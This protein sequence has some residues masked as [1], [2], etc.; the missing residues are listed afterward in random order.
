[1]GKSNLILFLGVLMFLVGVS[2]KVSG[3]QQ[4]YF[5]TIDYDKDNY[6]VQGVELT[7]GGASDF[8]LQSDGKFRF[9]VAS[10]SNESLFSSQLYLE[11]RICG[12]TV[13][14]P[15]T[16]KVSG[17]CRMLEKGTLSLSIPYY[18]NGKSIN[19]YDPAGK[20][21]LAVDISDFAD[22]CGD[23]ICQENENAGTCQSDC[24]SG[25]SDKYCDKLEDGVC[26]PDCAEAE[27]QDCSAAKGV[28]IT[29][30]VIIGAFLS[31]LIVAAAFAV[32]MIRKKRNSQNNR[33]Q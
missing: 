16:Q 7:D 27:D 9:E 1:M 18:P 4:S 5:L 23:G 31:I 33:E 3:G 26:D 14:D 13:L 20:L 21:I 24:R 32:Y 8:K 29:Q 15:V 22:L 11:K 17:G 2:D 6:S 30:V 10:F 28:N 12:D 25:A 19:F